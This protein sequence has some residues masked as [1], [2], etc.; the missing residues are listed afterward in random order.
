MFTRS[1]SYGYHGG[2]HHTTVHHTVVHH[3]TVVHHYHHSYSTYH[4]GD[5]AGRSFGAWLL[6]GLILIGVIAFFAIRGLK[7]R[8]AAGMGEGAAW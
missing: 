1:R 4:S 2:T 3:T 7:R 6:V 8:R 5:S